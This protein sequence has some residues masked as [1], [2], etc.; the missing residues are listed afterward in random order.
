MG[1]DERGVDVLFI[2]IF[3]ATLVIAACKLNLTQSGSCR[4]SST[5]GLELF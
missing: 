2:S 5:Q 1:A 4:A 3:V